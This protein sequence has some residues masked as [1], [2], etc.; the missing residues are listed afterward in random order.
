MAYIG[1]PLDQV[2]DISCTQKAPDELN[3]L[4]LN[5]WFT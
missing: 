1:V 3:S 4:Q 5:P 2:Y